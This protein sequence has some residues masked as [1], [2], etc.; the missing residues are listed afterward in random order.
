MFRDVVNARYQVIITFLF[1]FVANEKSSQGGTNKSLKVR[2]AA[3]KDARG[4]REYLPCDCNDICT[5][6]RYCLPAF[7]DGLNTSDKI[8]I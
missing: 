4:G 8:S 3:M 2:E 1:S 7:Y 6:Q 5:T